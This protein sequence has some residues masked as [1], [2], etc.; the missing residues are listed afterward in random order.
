MGFQDALHC[1]EL[2]YAS[3][4]AVEF[5]DHSMEFI[6]Y[7]AIKASSQLAEERGTYSSYEGSLWSQ[8]VLPVDSID[9]LQ[10]SRHQMLEQDRSQALDWDALH[11]SPTSVVSLPQ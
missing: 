11:A 3:W 9:L 4:D 8:G 7:Y 10:E 1:L 5:A 6:S 2:D